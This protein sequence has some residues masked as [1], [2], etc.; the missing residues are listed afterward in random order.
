[1]LASLYRGMETAALVHLGDT[2]MDASLKA[3]QSKDIEVRREYRHKVNT[4]MDKMTRGVNQPIE[5]G[6]TTTFQH[7]R[8]LLDALTDPEYPAILQDELK[9]LI[10]PLQLI[11]SQHN[12]P[13]TLPLPT[14]PFPKTMLAAYHNKLKRL[15]NAQHPEKKINSEQVANVK[16]QK[17]ETTAD[18]VQEEEKSGDDA[19]KDGNDAQ[20]EAI[21]NGNIQEE[22]NHKE[23]PH[24][25]NE[26]N[27]DARFEDA[28]DDQVMPDETYHYDDLWQ[29]EPH[30]PSPNNDLPHTQWENFKAPSR[31]RHGRLPKRWP[32]TPNYKK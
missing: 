29:D 18:G 22:E 25:K 2:L 24:T 12:A 20:K 30:S 5:K 21:V 17:K 11:P 28:D 26:S 9:P 19:Q 31:Q 15:Q 4:I 1:M 8:H 14:V 7:I 6:F 13:H 27:S 16:D 3:A 10:P 32:R 23:E